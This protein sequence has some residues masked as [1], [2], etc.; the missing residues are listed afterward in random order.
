[1][2]TISYPAV[3]S[4]SGDKINS[5]SG[6][7]QSENDS[8]QEICVNDYDDDEDV[9][10]EPALESTET[11]LVNHYENPLLDSASGSSFDQ[12]LSTVFKRMLLRMTRREA[13]NF[14][15]LNLSGL[16]TSLEGP[17]DQPKL[18]TTIDFVI[19]GSYRLH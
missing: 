13:S 11:S 6:P 14:F 4:A 7:S 10:L 8:Q 18:D 15:Q 5:G 2:R 12:H 1:M 3:S 19:I 17:S 16:I 9:E